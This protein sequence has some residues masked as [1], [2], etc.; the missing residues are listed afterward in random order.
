MEAAFLCDCSL[1]DDTALLAMLLQLPP[2]RWE[3]VAGDRLVTDMGHIM[4]FNPD[5]KFMDD[6]VLQILDRQVYLTDPTNGQ[7]LAVY[8]DRFENPRLA[9]FRNL[10]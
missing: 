1:L 3:H 7:T 8:R 5:G 2:D 9:V 4:L 6:S 10:R